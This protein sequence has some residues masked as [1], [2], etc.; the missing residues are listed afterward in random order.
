LSF[1]VSSPAGQN[2]SHDPLCNRCSSCSVPI[3]SLTC[4]SG[5]PSIPVISLPRSDPPITPP[6]PSD[7]QSSDVRPVEVQGSLVSPVASSSPVRHFSDPIPQG[8]RSF[9]SQ[10]YLSD[11]SGDRVRRS[12]LRSVISISSGHG[13]SA[14]NSPVTPN[15][16]VVSPRDPSIHDD[17]FGL[18]CRDG[19]DRSHISD[20]RG[21]SSIRGVPLSRNRSRSPIRDVPLGRNRSRSPVRDGRSRDG[22]NHRRSSHNS[23]R[24][25]SLD[26]DS[27]ASRDLESINNEI[28]QLQSRI[29]RARGRISFL[30]AEKRRRAEA[31]QVKK[32]QRLRARLKIYEDVD[33][34]GRSGP[35]SSRRGGGSM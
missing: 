34:A 22:S 19:H 29:N 27:L 12:P 20:D 7:P 2:L 24:G 30:S 32:R 11:P 26:R 25:S 9:I 35:D 18:S 1:F 15:V 16:P 14:H 17:P 10:D 6:V 33:F 13:G 5:P 28:S 31:E 4:D 21:R 8:S 3:V 23:S